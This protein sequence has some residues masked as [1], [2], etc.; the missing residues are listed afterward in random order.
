MK[1]VLVD[2]DGAAVPP[3]LKDASSTERRSLRHRGA[4]ANLSLHI[5]SPAQMLANR[6][7]ARLADVV[8]IASYVY[9]ADQSVSR[10]GE[11]DAHGDRW[12]RA[13]T[14]LI[15]VNDPAFWTQKDVCRRLS[16][17]LD[18]ASGDS[19]RFRF[20]QA[21]PE[22]EQLSFEI[23]PSFTLGSPDC[24]YLFSGGLDSLCAVVEAVAG[25]GKRPLLLGHSPAFNL[26]GKQ[27]ELAQALRHKLGSWHFPYIGA[28]IHRV[29]PDPADY[30]QRT[31]AFLYAALG[32]VIADGLGLKEVCL[33]DNGVVSLHL[34]MNY[35]LM[36]ARASRST[37][38]KFIRLFNDFSELVLP[39]APKVHNP[40]WA[41][42]RP[43]GLKILA[44]S[45]AAGLIEVANSCSHPRYLTKMQSHC[46][47]CS[48]CIDRRF[49]T[50][51]VGLEEF[52]PPERYKVDIFR[53]SIGD[54]KDRMM[55]LSYVR[56]AIT[57]EDLGEEAMFREFPELY[58]CIDPSDPGSGKVAETLIAMLRR[59]ASA[60]SR[61]ME[62]Q[63]ASAK[64]ELAR[65]KLPASCLIR[66]LAGS[67]QAASCSGFAEQPKPDLQPLAQDQYA[68]RRQGD[69][70][71]ACFDGKLSS[72]K[73]SRG[74]EYIAH[75]LANPHKDL[76][77][78]DLAML[79]KKRPWDEV[80]S[81]YQTMNEEQLAA[82]G[83][84]VSGFGDAGEVLDKTAKA[85]YRQHIQDID[86]ELRKA[87]EFGN[88]ERA[89]E[90]QT[91]KSCILQQLA[92]AVGLGGRD[93]TVADIPDRVR[94]TVRQNI[95]R[96]IK[97]IATGDTK[98][99]AFLRNSIKTGD[100]C[101][102]RPDREIP[103]RLDSPN[104]GRP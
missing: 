73:H 18:F 87:E 60:V 3:D 34:P 32:A 41:R 23:D 49:A 101:V 17:V 56:Y 29:G 98:L 20:S 6:V 28:A 24:I 89:K 30:T 75:L 102:Y 8:R 33:A 39:N 61:V 42:T 57:V 52:D 40:L 14:L 26:K 51:A 44:D 37:H 72:L 88:V 47:V 68:F 43:E 19:W 78:L 11:T 7:E 90:L 71:V 2:C 76:P 31:R 67:D 16:A 65:E 10:G 97:H 81:E 86:E 27:H 1:S 64:A 13:F 48:Q 54:W 70:W 79:G 36:R 96:A 21:A 53:Q 12:A 80:T 63:I 69:F 25:N 84:R 15:P 55:A 4:R 62:E 5:V 50:L 59:H 93:R 46:G 38:P 35:Q 100:I 58:E 91:E 83:L 9:A 92:A 95:N 66:L 99:A 94:I 74:L 104:I 22:Y 45:N 103:W 82:Q 85:E 77:A